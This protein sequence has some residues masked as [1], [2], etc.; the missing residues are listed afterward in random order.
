M[1][2]ASNLAPEVCLM[3]PKEALD[4]F[5]GITTDVSVL[6]KEIC[7]VALFCMLF[8]APDTFKSL[9]TRIGISK[10]S[11]VFGDIDVSTAG[12]TVST[13]NHGLGESIDRL[14]QIQ[15]TSSDPQ[16]KNDVS[17]V[18]DYLKDLQQQAQSADETI[19]SSIVTQQAAA[20]QAS[21]HLAK[22]PGW[23]Y[24]GNV[25]KDQTHWTG[26]TSKNVVPASLSPKLTAGQKF[27]V[28]VT[29]YLRDSN[30]KGKVIGVI[31][32][33]DQVQVA[34]TPVCTPSLSGGNVCWVKVQPL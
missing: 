18:T 9:L 11:T 26:D 1:G 29:A 33:N 7:I 20:E 32:A 5:V 22:P 13:L 28:A 34:A 24:L 30:V 15:S 4:D 14:Q 2:A 10:V 12:G 31:R 17:K 3:K 19:K 8:F 16:A 27:N 25:D 23:I 21:P 6:L